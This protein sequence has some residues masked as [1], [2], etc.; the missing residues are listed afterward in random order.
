MLSLEEA[1]AHRF[2][3][4]W[5]N[6][7]ITLPKT[8]D[9]IIENDVDLATI[10][11]YIDWSPFFWAW[12]LK[13]V[14]PKILEHKKWGAQAKQ[15]HED[16]LQLLDRIIKEKAFNAKFALRLCYAN[17]VDDDIILYK[18]P[19]RKSS[20]GTIPTLRQQKKKVGDPIYY[21]LADFI[22]PLD[23]DRL[24]A[25]GAFISSIE[26]V[27]SF[28]KQFEE[29]KDDYTSILVKALGDR[30]A[31][32]LTEYTHECVRKHHWGYQADENLS[33]EA[34]VKEEYIGIRPA[35]GYPACPDHS[36]LELVWEL[37]DGEKNT[38]ATLTENFAINPASTVSGLY[39]A[40]EN[41][42]YF[43]VGALSKEQMSDY[44][45]RKNLSLAEC[46]RQLATNKGY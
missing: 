13:G 12:E 20:L 2:Q 26:K 5:A 22:A 18:D 21:S 6:F 43:H 40:H 8:T 17:S 4:D 16:A 34:L 24:D 29:D 25:C 19:N 14:Y 27:D 3:T 1:R 23:S 35:L 11:K 9:L 41:A 44:A 45:Q 46:E 10:A 32:A 15:L 28:A 37:L 30:M 38:G 31:E 36:N 42:N 39:F 7:N 33:T